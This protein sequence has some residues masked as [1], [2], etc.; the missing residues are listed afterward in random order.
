MLK[1][2]DHFSRIIYSIKKNFKKVLI[3]RK[4]FLNNCHTF[5]LY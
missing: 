2:N 4:Y 5:Q 1:F 3:D